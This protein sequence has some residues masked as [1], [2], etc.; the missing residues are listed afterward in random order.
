VLLSI[1]KEREAKKV[2]Y[3]LEITDVPL[4]ANKPDSQRKNIVVIN[5]C[6]AF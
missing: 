1:F 3:E 2:D 6:E 5:D 4:R